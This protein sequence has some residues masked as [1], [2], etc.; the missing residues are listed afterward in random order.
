MRFEGYAFPP[1]S[2]HKQRAVLTL[3]NQTSFRLQFKDHEELVSLEQ[4][5]FS[6]SVGN[7]PIRLTF[8]SGWAFNADDSDSLKELA[9]ASNKSAWLVK[10]EQYWLAVLA[11][12]L[13][14]ISLTIAGFY[15]GVPW[16]S[17]AI[18]SA[19]PASVE[20]KFGEQVFSQFERHWSASDVPFEV[21]KKVRERLKQHL[22]TIDYQGM[23][24]ELVF[25]SMDEQANAFAFPGG[26][27]VVLDG[28]VSLAQNDQQLDSIIL[29]EVGHV[30][31]RHV[32]IQVVESS[33]VAIGVAVLTGE[34]TGAL[35][36]MAGIGAFLLSN[37]RSRQAE[38]QA[39]MFA[40][41][42]MI[43][44]YGSAQPMVEIFELL[45]NTSQFEIPEW[46]STHPE[47]QQR[48]E[49]LQQ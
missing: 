14:C 8:P 17:R 3:Y 35:D 13:L 31:H 22:V 12:V 2:S 11:S 37:G 38:Q 30:H 6:D 44:I 9:I 28:L 18:V 16:A 39:D 7:L 5:K 33:I 36:S 25:R 27:I 49:D 15:Y 40:K 26:T 45:D 47:M 48:I 23:P 46:I 20:Q 4:V 29:H 10:L 34:A 1:H 42:A 24:I 19:V 41:Q 32:M 21:R 43:D